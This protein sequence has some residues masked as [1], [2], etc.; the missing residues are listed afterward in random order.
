M[1]ALH[2]VKKSGVFAI[3]VLFA[4]N[5]FNFYDRN[6]AGALTEPMRREFH[7]NDT[8]VGLLGTAFTLLYAVIGVPL[9]K[10]ADVWSRRKLLSLG[11]LIWAALTSSTYFVGSFITLLMS[12]L[13][14]GVG[15]ATCAP[16]GTSW[17]GDLVPAERRAKVMGLFMLGIPVGG[18]PQLLLQRAGGAGLRLAG[19]DGAGCGSRAAA[20]SRPARASRTRAGRR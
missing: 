10:I 7:L 12:R 17:L 8:Q 4:I 15:E 20:D 2:P 3:S 6:V 16:A 9:G 13:G 14:V 19:R 18:S 1:I 11:V 5:I